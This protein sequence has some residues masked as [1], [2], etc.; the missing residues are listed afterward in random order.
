MC[1]YVFVSVRMCVSYI[2]LFFYFS[3]IFGF[4]NIVLYSLSFGF[5]S[6]LFSY[7]GCKRE[8]IMGDCIKQHF[9]KMLMLAFTFSV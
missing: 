5:T 6:L 1:V 3:F 4:F 8:N 9:E 2:V 7:L